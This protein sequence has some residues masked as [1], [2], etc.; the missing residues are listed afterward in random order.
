MS[1][2]EFSADEQNFLEYILTGLFH[3]EEMTETVE[4]GKGCRFCGF[5]TT[6]HPDL[7]YHLMIEHPELLKEYKTNLDNILYDPVNNLHISFD[8]AQG[9]GIDSLA[10]QCSF[11]GE[12]FDPEEEKELRRHFNIVHKEEFEKAKKM[13]ESSQSDAAS[14]R[15]ELSQSDAA[16][17][18]GLNE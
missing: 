16:N 17:R 8:W 18:E 2:R 5:K 12:Q 11:C 7:T 15:L 4:Q 3:T 14:R 9:M 13:I 1:K 6:D 10:N